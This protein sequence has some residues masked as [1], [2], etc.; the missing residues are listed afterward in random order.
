MSVLEA[1]TEFVHEHMSHTDVPRAKRIY[2]YRHCLRVAAI[3]RNVALSEGLDADRLELACLLHDIGKFDS[4]WHVD[5]GRAGAKIV[6]PFLKKQGLDTEA[7]EEICQGIAM[8]TDG[9]WNY[10]PESPDYRGIEDYAHEPSMLARS[11][12]DCDNIDRFSAYRI[13]DTL[14][15]RRFDRMT[16][17]HQLDFC[18]SYRQRLKREGHYE[19]ATRSAQ[20]LWVEALERQEAYFAQL[21]REMRAGLPYEQRRTHHR[22]RK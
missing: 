1:A 16:L 4:T 21:E 19:C 20:R 9:R 18:V 2:R 8:H 3:G 13:H 7:I 22:H 10:P 6:R 15:Y 11:V 14:V 5:H 12:G 17:Q